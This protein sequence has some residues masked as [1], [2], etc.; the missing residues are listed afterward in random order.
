MTE[1]QDRV[2]SCINDKLI[3]FYMYQAKSLYSVDILYHHHVQELCCLFNNPLEHYT[4]IIS[5]AYRKTLKE[6]GDN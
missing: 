2:S 5:L 6:L 3:E 1:Y 4:K